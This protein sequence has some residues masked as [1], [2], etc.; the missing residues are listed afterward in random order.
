MFQYNSK[1]SDNKNINSLNEE[2]IG[3]NEN[4]LFSAQYMKRKKKWDSIATKTKDEIVWKYGKTPDDK[5]V[6][7]LVL[8]DY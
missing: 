2:K 8:A 6:D 7:Q 1:E 5:D 3:F 4:P